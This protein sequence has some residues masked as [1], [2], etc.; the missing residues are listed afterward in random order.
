[1]NPVGVDP[2]TILTGLT[3]VL[4]AIFAFLNQRQTRSKIRDRQMVRDYRRKTIQVRVS[5]RHIT[6]LEDRLSKYE[7]VP[8]RP[9]EAEIDYGYETEDEKEEQPRSKI[10][11]SGN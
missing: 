11:Q 3:G 8:D 9:P 10:I 2:G 1:M 5:L 4:V 6:F 7:T